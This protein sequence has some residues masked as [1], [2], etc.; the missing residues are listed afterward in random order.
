MI[1]NL[2]N[3]R[4]VPSQNSHGLSNTET[5]FHYFQSG[6]VITGHYRGGEIIEGN[7]VGKLISANQMELRFQCLTRSLELRSGKSRGLI[8]AFPNN[9]L[10][11]AF[12]WA[13]LDQPGEGGTSNYV[14]L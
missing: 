6:E 14:E 11:L 5:V 3:K 2:N 13:W 12:E 4:F 1:F 8:S 7:F 9:K 10:A